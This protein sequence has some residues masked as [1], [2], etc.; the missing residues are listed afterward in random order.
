MARMRW[1]SLMSF[2]W[3]GCLPLA[4]AFVLLV[5]SILIAF[6]AASSPLNNA[7]SILTC[8][9]MLPVHVLYCA[10]NTTSIT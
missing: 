9:Y 1:D 8:H 2:C 4:I 7:Y 5:P 3:T 10:Y 6:D